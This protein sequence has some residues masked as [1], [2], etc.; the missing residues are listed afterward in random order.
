MQAGVL[1]QPNFYNSLESTLH[2]TLFL[3]EEHKLIFHIAAGDQTQP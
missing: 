3:G 2:S 1:F